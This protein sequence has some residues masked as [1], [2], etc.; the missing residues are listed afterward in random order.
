[1]FRITVAFM[2]LLVVAPLVIGPAFAEG[3]MRVAVPSH[4]IPRGAT[5]SDADLAYQMVAGAQA[6]VVTSMNQLDGM[7]AR[8]VLRAGETV[9]VDDV[10]HPIVVTKG[11]LVT[12]TFEAPGI[13]LTA[14]GK[15]TTEGGIGEQVTVVNPVSYRQ[16]ICT[17]V[18]PGVVRADGAGVALPGTNLLA[19]NTP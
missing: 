12:M 8:R 19:Q 15:A 17:V 5:I 11:S 14:T 9:R 16:I 2:A 7:E 10:R 3:Q 4:D 6:G 18:G 13:T 1:M